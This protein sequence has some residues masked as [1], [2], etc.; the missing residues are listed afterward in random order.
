[1]KNQIDIT[2]KNTTSAEQSYK[3]IYNAWSSAKEV[4]S[5]IESLLILT[6]ELRHAEQFSNR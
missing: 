1:M 6:Q 2:K 4:G 3:R 5:R